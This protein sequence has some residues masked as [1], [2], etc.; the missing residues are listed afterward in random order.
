MTTW[1]QQWVSYEELDDSTLKIYKQCMERPL[2][3]EELCK[4]WEKK[5]ICIQVCKRDDAPVG[6][7][8]ALINPNSEVIQI[9]EFRLNTTENTQFIKLFMTNHL[10]ALPKYKIWYL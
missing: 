7:M 9:N 4:R 10:D 6:F 8:T 3:W 2:V 5:N 1:A